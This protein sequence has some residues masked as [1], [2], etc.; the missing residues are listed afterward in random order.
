MSGSTSV[1]KII[2]EVKFKTTGSWFSVHII[3]HIMLL[4][5]HCYG[6]LRNV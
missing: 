4:K 1:K 6:Y 5:S 2:T 3:V